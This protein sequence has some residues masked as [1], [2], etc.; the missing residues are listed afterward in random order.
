VVN[1]AFHL[2]YQP[3]SAENRR[4][5]LRAVGAMVRTSERTFRRAYRPGA[6]VSGPRR[7]LWAGR[8]RGALSQSELGEVNALIKRI[9]TI[10]RSGRQ[11]R[12]AGSRTKRAFYELT[13]VL[14]PAF[15]PE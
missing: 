2:K 3:G 6:V 7:N 9:L 11:D 10:M 5:V 4:A 15:R 8:A 13:F 12:K 14:A 1:R